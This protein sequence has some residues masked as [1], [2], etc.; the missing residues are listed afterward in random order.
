MKKKYLPISIDITEQKILIIGAGESAFSKA[1]ILKRFNAEIEF[2]AIE[3]CDNIRNSGWH[4]TQKP[5][6]VSDLKGYLMVY[7]CSNNLKLDKQIVNDAKAKGIL[8]NIHDKPDLCQYISP[9]VYQYKNMTVAVASNGE[10]VFNSI[11][12]R[13]YLREHL[14]TNI[15][16]I[17]KNDQTKEHLISI[18]GAGPGDPELL[19]IKA[20]NRLFNADVVLYDALHGDSILNIAKNAELIYAGKLHNDGQNQEERQNAI[21]KKLLELANQGKK[22]VRL[23]AGDPMVFGRGAEEIRFCKSHNIKYEV[24][25]GITTAVAASSLL[26]VPL[27]ERQKSPMVLFYTGRRTADKLLNIES[28]F[29]VLKGGGSVSMY[30]GMKN[31]S[32]LA[33]QVIEHGIDPNIPV[34]ILSQVSQEG[35]SIITS[36]LKDIDLTIHSERPK[37]PAIFLI[38]EYAKRI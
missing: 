27:T 38:G 23:K 9:A 20:H 2:V 5:Y 15:E 11:K 29:E 3:I 18:V 26:E 36:T 13:N 1:K 30:M 14:D 21:H 31:V 25:P 10:N 33:K 4:Y 12:L 8:V 28:V 34:Q 16:N 22:V 17:L 19:T 32:I 35:Q 6:D 7:S 24:V 37:T